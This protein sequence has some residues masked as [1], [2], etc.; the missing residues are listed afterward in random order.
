MKIID[1]LKWIDQKVMDECKINVIGF[2]FTELEEI[3]IFERIKKDL[4]SKDLWLSYGPVKLELYKTKCSDRLLKNGKIY[5]IIRFIAKV[6]FDGVCEKADIT[7][8]PFG[9]TRIFADSVYEEKAIKR[10]S[11]SLSKFMAEKFDTPY[12]QSRKGYFEKI[13][14]NKI[15]AAQMEA[16]IKVKEAEEEYRE[17][18]FEI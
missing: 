4:E 15:K 17:N 2:D 16:D 10:I 7:L 11:K 3:E 6:E 12:V 5:P 1:Y 18:M 9:C 13:K 8:N 14:N